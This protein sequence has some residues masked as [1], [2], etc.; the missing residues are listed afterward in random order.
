MLKLKR[1]SMH[2]KGDFFMNTTIREP[3]CVKLDGKNKYVVVSY[4][5]KDSEIVYR[6]LCALEDQK[7]SFWYDKDNKTGEDWLENITNQIEN[8]MC[9][10]I[11]IFV[12]KYSL[13]SPSVT[14]ELK[15]I[16][17][18]YEKNK[19]ALF[20]VLVDHD[21][22]VSKFSLSSITR[23][24]R[25][26][27]EN[28]Y[29]DE[30]Y[31]ERDEAVTKN[32]EYI[33]EFT[34]DGNK[35]FGRV[36]VGKNCPLYVNDE[37]CENKDNPPCHYKKSLILKLK[38]LKALSS[39]IIEKEDIEKEQEE[40]K[41]IIN[42]SYN[43]HP[44][45]WINVGEE[46]GAKCFVCN[47]ILEYCEETHINQV[48]EKIRKSI[49]ISKTNDEWRLVDNNSIR[50]LTLK[51]YNAN[52]KILDKAFINHEDKDHSQMY[53]WISDNKKIKIVL[54]DNY[55]TS[56]KLYSYEKLGLRPVIVLKELEGE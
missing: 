5:H 8:I 31:D 41:L 13:A 30:D 37:N 26:Y 56:H 4:S 43:R 22:V 49:L 1:D 25:K 40:K 24:A 36:C 44:I 42:D 18:H 23:A 2:S 29:S 52:K 11:I 10:G 32:S 27:V 53:W 6:E 12:S 20:I 3:K 48:I 50:L 28:E 33:K 47:E 35:L 17:E 14:E 54:P 39:V 34:N 21:N 7:A 16:S 46:N 9:V 55:V 15:Y 38:E 19:L 51:E 45:K